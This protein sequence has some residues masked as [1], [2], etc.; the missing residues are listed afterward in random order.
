[1]RKILERFLLASLVAAAVWACGG[2]SSSGGSGGASGTG[3]SGGAAPLGSC[4]NP[5]DFQAIEVWDTE[6]NE[7]VDGNLDE[8]E[9]Q[10]I[11]SGTCGGNKGKELV[12]KWTAPSD[13]VMNFFGLAAG[14]DIVVY[15]S[16]VCGSPDDELACV[17]R[18]GNDSGDALGLI[19]EGE[20]IYI[21]ADSRQG[22]GSEFRIKLNFSPVLDENE[23]CR[24]DGLTGICKL[25]LVCNSVS[26]F[27]GKNTAPRFTSPAPS[28]IRTP[29]DAVVIDFAGEDDEGNAQFVAL[30]FFGEDGEVL[31]VDDAGGTVMVVPVP[32]IW[33]KRSFSSSLESGIDFFKAIPATKVQMALIDY[34]PVYEEPLEQSEIVEVDVQRQ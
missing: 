25:G 23:P 31:P 24:T 1:M 34:D 28:V 32:D 13:G 15:A 10:A 9:A 26:G 27:C 20:S 29:T 11:L 4:E 16:K 8:G 17:A 6:L 21:V 22:T 2:D 30:Q 3:G 33:E 12:Y 14:A 7:Y 18:P 19:R 5:I